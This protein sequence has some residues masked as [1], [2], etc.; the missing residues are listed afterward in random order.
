MNEIGGE[1]HEY[2]GSRSMKDD[3]FSTQ[4]LD[5][6]Q[7]LRTKLSSE[8]IERVQEDEAIVHAIN[9]YTRALQEGLRIVGSS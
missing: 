7:N 8:V 9:E 6:V 1:L 5:E 3:H 2:I 4:V